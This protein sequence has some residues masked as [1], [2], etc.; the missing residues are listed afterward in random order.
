M[1]PVRLS[2]ADLTGLNAAARVLLSPFAF[3]SGTIWRHEVCRAIESLI[4]ATRS[5]SSIPLDGE[6]F[7]TGEPEV[8]DALSAHW[9]HPPC[10][11]RG[12]TERR[13]ALGLDVVDWTEIMD[14]SEV[15]A[16]DFYEEVVRPHHL[17]A[18]LGMYTELAELQPC[19]LWSVQSN[20]SQ[21]TPSLFSFFS[22]DEASAL[23]DLEWRKT[24]LQLL[25]PALHTGMH[26]YVRARRLGSRLSELMDRIDAP[27]AI[28][29]PSGSIVHQNAALTTLLH[30]DQ[31]RETIRAAVRSIVRR[32]DVQVRGQH[33]KVNVESL[34]EGQGSVVTT[35]AGRYS[36]YTTLVA[37]GTI[38]WPDSA[39][40]VV[41]RQA[42]AETAPDLAARYHLTLREKEALQLLRGGASTRQVAATMHISL[43][44]ARRHVERVLTK[45]G[46]HSRVAAVTMIES[47]RDLD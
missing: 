45:L 33:T 22:R 23:R 36:L 24:V 17:W 12:Y 16:T 26:T 10:V 44:T 4:G 32:V 1:S 28:C 13:A 6:D 34:G 14:V 3:E 15:R 41:E 42:S 39:L 38:G 21:S 5:I 2:S 8:I 37:A 9:P 18:P 40:V 27:I 30:G 43:N 19:A 29:R 25:V 46:V 47:Q 20:G 7:W 11:I 31:E 35:R